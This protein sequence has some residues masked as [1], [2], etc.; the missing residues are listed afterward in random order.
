[1]KKLF[2]VLAVAIIAFVLVAPVLA[3]SPTTGIITLTGGS[4]SVAPQTIDFGSLALSGLVQT[5]PGTT[6]NWVAN[7]PTGNGAGWNVTIAAAD[8]KRNGD[9]AG[10]EKL[11]PVGG[12][13]MTLLNSAITPFDASVVSPVPTSS[14]SADTVL[15]VAQKFVSADVDKGMGKYNMLPTFKLVVPADTYAGSYTSQV[16][17]VITA[18]P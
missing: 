7:D 1:M 16:T 3:D 2:A 5:Q 17:L 9:L 11:I 8:F 13:K 15:G 6:T 12:F 4:L 10:S 14:I 18:A